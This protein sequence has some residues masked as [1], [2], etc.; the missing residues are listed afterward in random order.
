MNLWSVVFLLK[1]QR[2]PL[3]QVL[4]VLNESNKD[5]GSRAPGG[6]D[7][8]VWEAAEDFSVRRVRGQ[9]TAGWRAQIEL[10]H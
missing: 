5:R 4:T 2:I 8:L 7:Q 1:E 6:S 3:Y 10:V 9:P